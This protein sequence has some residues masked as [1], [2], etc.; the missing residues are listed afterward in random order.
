MQK[1]G[2]LCFFPVSSIFVYGNK[3]GFKKKVL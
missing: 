3:T 2:D 1:E